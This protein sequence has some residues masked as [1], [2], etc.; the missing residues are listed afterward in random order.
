MAI[1]NCSRQQFYFFCLYFSEKT[2]LDVLCQSSARHMIHMKNQALISLKKEN[3]KMIILSTAGVSGA[4]RLKIS[5]QWRLRLHCTSVQ[6]DGCGAMHLHNH[7]IQKNACVCGWGWRGG[8]GQGRE[9]WGSEMW[10]ENIIFKFSQ[11]V[12][13][14]ISYLHKSQDPF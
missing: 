9:G 10:S 12:A 13:G 4:S 3:K 7:G 5:I 11:A 14:K 6:S 1:Q 8:R 2:I